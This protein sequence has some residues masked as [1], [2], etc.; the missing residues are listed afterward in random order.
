M[1]I[2]TRLD[3]ETRRSL[4]WLARER[5]RSESDVLREAL[6]RLPE[7][8]ISSKDRDRVV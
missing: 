2:K 7:E 8:R 1:S 3:A 5:G 4:Q 6:Q